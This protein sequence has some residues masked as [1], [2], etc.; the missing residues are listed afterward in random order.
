MTRTPKPEPASQLRRWRTY[1]AMPW[2][3]GLGTTL[4]VAREP[5]TG[6][7]FR[8]RLSLAGIDRDSEFSAYPGYSRALVLIEGSRL[9]L[10][11]QRHGRCLLD[12]AHRAVRF[13]G[14]WTTRCRIPDGRCADLSLIVHRGADRRPTAVVRTPR[15]LRISAP[16]EVPLARGL[17]GALFV[18]TGKLAVLD[19]AD[20]RPHLLRRR[21]TLLLAPGPRRVLT[22]RRAA[23]SPAEVIFLRWHPGR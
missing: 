15:I 17:R 23:A 10:R 14:D 6:E 7:S 2:R 3:N 16:T 13:E 22:L 21:D 4:E 11:F 5:P 18:L 19:S 8:W 20:A 1:R 9:E 12:P